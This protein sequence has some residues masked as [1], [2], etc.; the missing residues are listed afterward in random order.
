MRF[1]QISYLLFFILISIFSCRKEPAPVPAVSNPTSMQQLSVDE[2]LIQ[3]VSNNLINDFEMVISNSSFSFFPNLRYSFFPTIIDATIDSV[4]F[5]DSIIYQIKYNGSINPTITETRIGMLQFTKKKGQNWLMIG[6]TINIQLN[7]I[8]VA[9]NGTNFKLN[10]YLIYSNITIKPPHG[11]N[12]ESVGFHRIGGIIE[13]LFS[14]STTTR[15]WNLAKQ[16]TVTQ[17]NENILISENGF[18]AVDGYTQ[19]ISWG[20]DRQGEEFYCVTDSVIIYESGCRWAPNSG[21]KK[22]YLLKNNYNSTVTFGFDINNKPITNS[23]CSAKYKFEWNLNDKLQTI[24]I[25]NP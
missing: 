18:G 14:N 12:N 10:G 19:L 8:K 17:K 5:Q 9:R 25:D 22:L 1:N 6:N 11:I 15:L 2:N 20:T 16:F 7:D 4:V 3:S 21:Q 23:D 13:I 24:F